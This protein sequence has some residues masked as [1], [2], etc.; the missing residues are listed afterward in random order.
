MSEELERD[1]FDELLKKSSDRIVAIPKKTWSPQNPKDEP[2]DLE[3]LQNMDEP[4][5][6]LEN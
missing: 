6:D 3:D 1:L 4:N 5:Q 2:N